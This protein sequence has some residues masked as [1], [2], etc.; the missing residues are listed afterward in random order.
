MKAI[1]LSTFENDTEGLVRRG[2]VLPDLDT[3]RFK[4]LQLAGLVDEEGPGRQ[5]LEAGQELAKRAPSHSDKK[6]TDPQNKGR[7]GARNGGRS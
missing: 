4:A 2:T 1:A 3:R 5:K 7:G 6:A